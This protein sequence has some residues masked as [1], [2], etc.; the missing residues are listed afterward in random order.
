MLQ[1]T[2]LPHLPMLSSSGVTP[3]IVTNGDGS[4]WMSKALNKKAKIDSQNSDSLGHLQNVC[5]SV[6]G[7]VLH[8]SHVG[9]IA[10]IIL[11]DLVFDQ[12]NWWT[13]LNWIQIEEECMFLWRNFFKVLHESLVKKVRL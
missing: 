2:V 7:A 5:S 1:I 6:A 9:S 13:T 11:A 4:M 12:C 3:K 8:L 10:D